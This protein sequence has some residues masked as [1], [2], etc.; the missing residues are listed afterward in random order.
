MNLNF[1]DSQF[2]LNSQI[3]LEYKFEYICCTL[4]FSP[5]VLLVFHE[6]MQLLL[7]NIRGK[8]VDLVLN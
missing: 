3:W 5:F 7:G 2:E 4:T 6:K 8:Y 1:S